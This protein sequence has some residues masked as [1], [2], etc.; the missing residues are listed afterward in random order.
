MNETDI[1]LDKEHS[2]VFKENAFQSMLDDKHIDN[3]VITGLV[4]NGCVQA[5]CTDGIKLGYSINLISDAHS[6]FH[7]DADQLIKE[8]NQKLQSEG[9]HVM[10]TDEY[11]KDFIHKQK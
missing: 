9:I 1:I 5:A 2:S 11:L 6:T 7:N 10:T 8:W 3:I 4:T